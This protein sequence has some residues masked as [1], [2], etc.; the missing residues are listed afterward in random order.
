MVEYKLV[1]KKVQFNLW[2]VFVKGSLAASVS[3]A[4]LPVR[5]E[6]YWTGSTC[7]KQLRACMSPDNLHH[8]FIRGDSGMSIDWG[9]VK[10]WPSW[11]WLKINQ[12][13]HPVGPI[14]ELRRN[15]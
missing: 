2:L 13:A 3:G 15:P 8:V 14:S 10:G 7:M 1:A 4:L 11:C 5:I 9:C 6:S 12:R